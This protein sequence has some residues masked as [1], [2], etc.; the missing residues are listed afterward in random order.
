MGALE[1]FDVGA[2]ETLVTPIHLELFQEDANEC[3]AV[4]CYAF[5]RSSWTSAR[6]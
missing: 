5:G 3:R 2:R 1:A 4:R 6:D